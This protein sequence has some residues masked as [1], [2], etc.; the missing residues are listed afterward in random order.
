MRKVCIK[1]TDLCRPDIHPLS[2]PHA[3]L[4]AQF[5]TALYTQSCREPQKSHLRPDPTAARADY[6]TWH[7]MQRLCLYIMHAGP[8]GHRSLAGRLL[9]WT[10]RLLAIVAA[11]LPASAAAIKAP[12]AMNCGP[13]VACADRLLGNI[14]KSNVSASTMRHSFTYDFKQTCRDRTGRAVT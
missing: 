13:E 5:I 1:C 4:Y 10:V 7:R 6:R 12:P 11:F 2:K 8:L 3:K 14:C 9:L